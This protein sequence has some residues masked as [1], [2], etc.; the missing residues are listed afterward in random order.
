[1]ITLQ[2]VNTEI[3]EIAATNWGDLKPG[4]KT[5]KK[6]RLAFLKVVKMYL[7]TSPS[8]EFCMVE[9]RRIERLIKSKQDQFDTWK[10]N[11][12]GLELKELKKLFKKEF[13]I[14][15]LMSQAKA[16]SFIINKN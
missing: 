3:A 9:Q 13:S 1:M 16:L 15:K 8:E 14:D 2:K 12:K 10:L 11:H 6:A 4:Q 7:E 5:R